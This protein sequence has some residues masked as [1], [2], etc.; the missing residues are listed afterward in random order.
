MNW[1]ENKQRLNRNK[2]VFNHK[3]VSSDFHL[4]ELT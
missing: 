1:D 3:I 2:Y 4:N